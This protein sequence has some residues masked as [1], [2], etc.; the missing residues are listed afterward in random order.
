[1]TYHYLESGLDNIYLIN[2]FEITKEDE[3]TFISFNDLHGLHEAIAAKL[4]HQTKSLNGKEFRFLRTEM[5]MSQN[6]LS[7]CFGVTEQ[8]VARWEKGQ[9]EIPRTSDVSL[10]SMYLESIKHESNISA[11]LSQIAENEGTMAKLEFEMDT[12]NKH[13]KSS[14]VA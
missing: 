5:D 13:W 9:T 12:Q 11:L 3:D 1:M 7:K 10:R 14:Q 8:T 6:T 4:V 2:G